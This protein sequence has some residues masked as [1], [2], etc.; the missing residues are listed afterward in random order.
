[1]HKDFIN[2]IE[3]FLVSS[4]L[5]ATKFGIYAIGNPSFVFKLR[6]GK[7]C[8]LRTAERVL[9]FIQANKDV[10]FRDGNHVVVTMPATHPKKETADVT[11]SK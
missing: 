8:T 9:N 10:N 2:K 7:S 6:N 5:D 11:S 3:D 4:G 1:M